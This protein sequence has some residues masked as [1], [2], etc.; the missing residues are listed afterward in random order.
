MISVFLGLAKA[1]VTFKKFRFVIGL[2]HLLA[3]K[4]HVFRASFP[5]ADLG[6]IHA[7]KG[8]FLAQPPESII[9]QQFR[10]ETRGPLS[11]ALW[12]GNWTGQSQF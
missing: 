8:A 4:L 5:V 3:V 7:T 9:R 10:S 2:G 1:H 11:S 12:Y 6:E